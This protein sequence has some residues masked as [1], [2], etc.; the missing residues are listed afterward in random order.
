MKNKDQTNQDFCEALSQ[1]NRETLNRIATKYL[2]TLKIKEN[3]N[4]NFENIKQWINTHDCV[5]SVEIISGMLRSDPPIK[6]FEISLKSSPHSSNIG[7]Q[8]FP[9]RLAFNYK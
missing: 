9:D 5:E 1:N 3:P 6:V 2:S 7:I 4:E 8:V